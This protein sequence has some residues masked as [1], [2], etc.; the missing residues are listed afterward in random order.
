ML[1]GLRRGQKLSRAYALSS[2]LYGMYRRGLSV[3]FAGVRQR[4]E[5]IES[6]CRVLVHLEIVP[7]QSVNEGSSVSMMAR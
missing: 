3:R 2:Y 6:Q 4:S 1:L 7:P 5:H